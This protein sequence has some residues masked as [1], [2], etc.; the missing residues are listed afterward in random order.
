MSAYASM[1]ILDATDLHRIASPDICIAPHGLAITADNT[2]AFVA[3]AGQDSLAIVHL[4]DPMLRTEL[5]PVG[6]SPSMAPNQAYGPYS[7]LITSD[8]QYALVADLEGQDI[9]VFNIATNQFEIQNSIMTR[10]ATFFGTESADG[11]TL[12]YPTQN[13]DQ[14]VRIRRAT[15]QIERVG[16]VPGDQCQLPHEI[17][18]GPDGKYYMVCEAI[19]NPDGTPGDRTR[20]SHVVTFDP[21]TLTITSVFNVGIYP[22]RVVFVPLGGSR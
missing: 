9:R 21:D 18:R 10:A 7:I 13:P 5:I 22:D 2:R 11:S 3:C 16:N 8:Q 1:W 4:D 14:I 19:R 20:P 17:S 6:P 12:Y 15:W